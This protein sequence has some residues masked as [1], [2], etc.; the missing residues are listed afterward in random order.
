MARIIIIGR[1][2][3][4]LAAAW[5]ILRS[6]DWIVLAHLLA[7]ADFNRLALAAVVFVVQF[8]LLVWRWRMI[9]EILG[10]ERTATLVELAIGL[11][12]SM[13][14]GQALPS[15]V[16]GDLVRVVAISNHIG[17][18]IAARSVVSDRIVGL[19]V[20]LTST[21]ATLPFFVHLVGSGPVFGVFAALSLATLAILVLFL[22][23]S[24]WLA[25]QS[26]I[27]KYP[28]VILADLRRLFGRGRSSWGVIMLALG[29]QLSGIILIYE[30]ARALAAQISLLQCLLIVPPTLLISAVPFSL[31]G[32]GVREG[33]LAA[34]F[35]LV[36][37]STEAGV[38]TSILFGLSGPLA[39]IIVELMAPLKRRSASKEEG[40]MK[41]AAAD[42]VPV[43]TVDYY[44][45]VAETWDKSH[46]SE[47]QSARFARQIR[48]QIK[49]LLASV[50]AEAQALEL[51]AGTGPYI[52]ITAPLFGHVIATDFSEG[53]L[54]IFARR[55]RALGLNNVTLFRQDACTLSGIAPESVD[56]VYSIGLL[57]TIADF[58]QLF[59]TIH[60]VLKPGG[61]VA[62]ITSNGH[63]PWYAMR[64]WVQGGERHGRTGRLATGSILSDVLARSGF[65]PPEIT[66][67][68]A[69]PQH[70]QNQLLC[71][72]LAVAELAIAPSPL[73]RYLG[74][75]SFRA[76]KLG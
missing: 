74:A 47:R 66:Y 50:P 60:R 64:R 62:G 71:G 10:G 26:W 2:A 48:D 29:A 27:R 21:I 53:M 33:A 30:L 52:G 57:E 12:R 67:W 54:A 49:L 61:I 24:D 8:A 65:S 13:L 22:T 18:A 58:D 44:D 59:I 23:Y 11:G 4:T 38:A 7:S 75:L 3:V 41:P 63:C 45:R 25:K 1:V 69:A 37:A 15:A 14:L 39:G 5:L 19:A 35:A 20:L 73:A 46:G 76:C 55:L 56:V 9:I 68:G 28:A 40:P 51:G 34:G 32:W 42:P 16:G 43:S 6:I 17:V 72:A 31:G 36:G 70:L